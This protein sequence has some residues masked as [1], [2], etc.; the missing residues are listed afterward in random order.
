ML[1][2]NELMNERYPQNEKYCRDSFQTSAFHSL[3][4]PFIN[5]HDGT[6]K[7]AQRVFLIVLNLL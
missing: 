6:H 2:T 1:P 5:H 7:L 3:S 4:Y